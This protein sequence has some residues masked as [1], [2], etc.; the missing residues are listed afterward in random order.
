MFC[1]FRFHNLDLTIQ[2]FYTF[3]YSKQANTCATL[4]LSCCFELLVSDKKLS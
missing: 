3:F 1:I 2:C 4:I